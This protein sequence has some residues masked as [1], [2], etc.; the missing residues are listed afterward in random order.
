[1][2]VNRKR[3]IIF[4]FP[5]L[6]VTSSALGL[7]LNWAEGLGLDIGQTVTWGVALLTGLIIGSSIE[8]DW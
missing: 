2:S 3:A 1:M 4:I 8:R 5:A 6:A 7:L